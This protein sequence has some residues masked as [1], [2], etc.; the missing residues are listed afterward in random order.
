MYY[1]DD[2]TDGIQM[3]PTPHEFSIGGVYM[4][5]L[6]VAALFGVI[7]D[8]H[9]FD[10]ALV[11]APVFRGVA[12]S[13]AYRRYQDGVARLLSQAAAPHARLHYLPREFA[14]EREQMQNADH[15]LA[16]GAARYTRADAAELARLPAE[17]LAVSRR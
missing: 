5:P 17:R 13:P 14:F 8:R 11:N 2:E 3:T 16:A 4:P 7:A 10:V 1:C 6:L 9:G 12:E 15:L